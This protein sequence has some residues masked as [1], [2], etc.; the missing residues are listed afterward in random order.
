[1]TSPWDENVCLAD[2]NRV[3]VNREQVTEW[4]GLCE[5]QYELQVTCERSSDCLG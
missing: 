4:Q 2:T 5:E 1:M 3:L